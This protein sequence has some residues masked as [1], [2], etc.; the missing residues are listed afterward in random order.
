M[1]DK[2]RIFE[3]VCLNALAQCAKKRIKIYNESVFINRI[4][5]FI[6]V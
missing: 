6:P 5:C 4:F 1:D 3:S 2:R